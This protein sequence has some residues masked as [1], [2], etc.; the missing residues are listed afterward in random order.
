[1][2]NLMFGILNLI[3]IHCWIP[4]VANESIITYNTKEYNLQLK[5]YKND[6]QNNKN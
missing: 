5:K 2:K 1:M 4:D 6:S 3:D